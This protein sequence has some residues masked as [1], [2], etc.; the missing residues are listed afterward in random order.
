MTN[1][2][3]NLNST[4]THAP[5]ERPALVVGFMASFVIRHSSFGFHHLPVSTTMDGNVTVNTEPL[6]A[7]LVTVMSPLTLE[8]LTGPR[9]ARGA[10]FGGRMHGVIGHWSRVIRI[11]SLARF[12]DDGR[13]RNSERRRFT[14]FDLPKDA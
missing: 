11:S 6:P 14:S 5:D 1:K 13:Q 9:P 7:S 10:G 12:D 4:G 3:P 2:T 8:K